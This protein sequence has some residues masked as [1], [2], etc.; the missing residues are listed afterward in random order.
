MTEVLQDASGVL[1]LILVLHCTVT[2]LHVSWKLEVLALRCQF[3]HRKIHLTIQI[4]D[5]IQEYESQEKPN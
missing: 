5:S 4:P 2:P 1:I 3:M